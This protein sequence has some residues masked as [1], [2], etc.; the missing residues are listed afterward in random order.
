[1]VLVHSAKNKRRPPGDQR[2]H[3]A[4][5]IRGIDWGGLLRL[6]TTHVIEHLCEAWLAGAKMYDVRVVAMDQFSQC[7]TLRIRRVTA[8][9]DGTRSMFFRRGELRETRPLNTR[10]P[11]VAARGDLLSVC[12]IV[13]DP[14]LTAVGV[15]SV[16]KDYDLRQRTIGG[17]LS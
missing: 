8:F 15:G 7:R 13:E 11:G 17:E 2:Q 16:A 9:H 5:E 12:T 10:L 3:G 1:M 4:H 6:P 14:G